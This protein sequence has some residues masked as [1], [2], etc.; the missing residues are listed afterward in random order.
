MTDEGLVARVLS[1]S[2]QPRRPHTTRKTSSPF[3]TSNAP[4][5]PTLAYTP[6]LSGSPSQTPSPRWALTVS[7]THSLFLSLARSVS[8]STSLSLP[9]PLSLAV[10]LSL[11]LSVLDLVPEAGLFCVASWDT[12]V[13]GHLTD[14]K[15]PSPLGPP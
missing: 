6:H 15:T 1:L 4:A 3:H 9:P 11:S 7:L 12:G 14:K 13:Q 8:F 2:P 10:S 5:P